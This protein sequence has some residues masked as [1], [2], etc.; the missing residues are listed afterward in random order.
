MNR[1]ILGQVAGVL[2][3]VVLLSACDRPP[4]GT[5]QRGP[6]GDAQVQVFNPREYQAAYEDFSI[7]E[8]PPP[9][10]ADGPRAKDVFQNVQV[11]GDLSATQMV[12][13]MTSM[14]TW[15]TGGEGCSYCHNLENPAEDTKYPKIV[16]R[17]ML[18]MVRYI[19]SH[20]KTHVGATGV[21]CYTCHRG[22]PVPANEWFNN[23][24]SV[25]QGEITGWHEQQAATFPSVV[26][27]D[28]HIAAAALGSLPPDPFTAYLEGDA[29][30]RVQPVD[31]LPQNGAG[32]S[33]QHAEWTYALMV[34]MS[35]S[36]GVNC[37]YCHNTQA[38]ADW[39]K[40]SPARATAWYGIRMVRSL[41]NNFLKQV[42]TVLPENRLGPMGDG[43]KL[44]CATC[45]QGIFKPMYGISMLK[46]YPELVGDPDQ[47]SDYL[48]WKTPH[49][50]AGTDAATPATPA[51]P[52]AP[53][54]PSAK[55]AAN[56]PA[57]PAAQKV[58][59]NQ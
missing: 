51:T 18:Q 13:V 41:N 56:E 19:N 59:L 2:G 21:T 15:V 12:R 10:D 31:A 1:R 45:H 44:Y 23:P 53:A 24:R 5:I 16:A 57:A 29:N 52:A 11:L 8:S 47:L 50:E 28:G 7:P 17:R 55:S 42:A 25:P 34:T 14:A 40:S 20:W 46:D 33:I 3:V 37:N 49:P 22:N 6:R 35:K 43:P 26:Q 32:E 36:L 54:K 9:A 27:G 48:Q 4:V 39:S 38:F 58:S 30:I